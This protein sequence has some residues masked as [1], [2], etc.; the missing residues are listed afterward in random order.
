MEDPF[1]Q[2]SL[3]ELESAHL[4]WER[5]RR[6]FWSAIAARPELANG[7]SN[8]PW[9][10]TRVFRERSHPFKRRR[11]AQCTDGVERSPETHPG[12]L[13]DE[14]T[15]SLDA[16]T[17]DGEAHEAGR[18]R[19]ARGQPLSL[20]VGP[21]VLSLS[22]GHRFFAA[23]S[24]TLAM[25]AVQCMPNHPMHSA[26]M[27]HAKDARDRLARV[28][29]ERGEGFE[30][31]RGIRLELFTRRTHPTTVHGVRLRCF[32]PY[33]PN[34]RIE[35]YRRVY[36]ADCQIPT[37]IRQ[38]AAARRQRPP[39]APILPTSGTY[40]LFSWDDLAVGQHF[41]GRGPVTGIV[42]GK[43][44]ASA[45]W[46]YRVSGFRRP[47]NEPDAAGVPLISEG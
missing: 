19:A 46:E 45:L 43:A 29:R 4:Q 15:H 33:A 40:V 35:L 41:N 10:G 23:V 5:K 37:T 44:K 3:G 9:L 32:T 2:L 24:K 6:I 7:V 27:E 42:T 38:P 22:H 17:E 12:W 31:P 28:P 47:Q 18:I 36:G 14:G 1:F 13:T 25:A 21:T 30:E 11:K 8:L 20:H 26:Y 34:Q 39:D 16:S